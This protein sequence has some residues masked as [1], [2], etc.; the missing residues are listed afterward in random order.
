MASS[1][2]RSL[3]ERGTASQKEIDFVL[4]SIPTIAGKFKKDMTECIETNI[5]EEEFLAQYGHLRPGTYDLTSPSYRETWKQISSS[6]KHLQCSED[7]SDP[8]P[9]DASNR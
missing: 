9:L 2:L 7:S 6:Q 3:V 8:D 1:F 5:A 4:S